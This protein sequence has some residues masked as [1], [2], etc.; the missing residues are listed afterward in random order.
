MCGVFAGL[1]FC[2]T[3]PLEAVKTR[4]QVMS[5]VGMNR[6]F[7]AAMLHI[8][9]HEG[10]DTLLLIS[11]SRMVFRP[12]VLFC[13]SICPHYPFNDISKLDKNLEIL[14]KLI[15]LCV[16]TFLFGYIE[17]TKYKKILILLLICILTQ[18]PHVPQIQ[19]VC[20]Q[21]GYLFQHFPIISHPIIQ[22]M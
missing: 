8:L 22:Y 2:V 13:P 20:T 14:E 3:H 17:T 19:I 9:K 12:P 16:A 10:K 11:V 15:S 21:G 1:C 6:G 7:L 4:V 5:A 18:C